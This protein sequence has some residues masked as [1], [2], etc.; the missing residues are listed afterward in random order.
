M[1]LLSPKKALIGVNYNVEV[2]SNLK[3]F[4][5]FYADNLQH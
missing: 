5:L 2:V 1:L 4:V 3:P